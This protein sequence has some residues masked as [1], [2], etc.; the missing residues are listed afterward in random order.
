[1]RWLPALL[2]ACSAA[3]AS[4]DDAR[5]RM[6]YLLH[7]GGC[8]LPDGRGVPPEVP[9][10]RGDPGRLAAYPDGRR[11]LARIPGASQAPLS[12]AELTAVLNWVLTEF[13]ADTLPADH[14]PLTVDEVASAR[15]DALADPARERRAIWERHSLD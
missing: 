15:R 2:L 10:L 7:C 4:A 8:H 1:M 3:G 11:Y 9:S 13:N 6:H 5:A 14:E 12:D